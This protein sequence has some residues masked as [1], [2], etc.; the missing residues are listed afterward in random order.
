M[1]DGAGGAAV[2][3]APGT[4][5][6]LMDGDFDRQ[7]EVVGHQGGCFQPP[8]Q[9][10]LEVTNTFFHAAVVAGEVGRAVQGQDAEAAHG[11]IHGVM[12]D[13][14]TVVAFKE[15]R[16]AVLPEVAFEMGGDLLLGT[17]CVA[18]CVQ[19]N[20]ETEIFDNWLTPLVSGFDGPRSNSGS[21]A[22]LPP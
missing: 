19:L 21:G 6:E 15:Q 20:Y 7:G 11:F 12:I 14:R 2:E 3:A 1:E 8:I 22:R 9:R 5:I 10:L 17:Q 4:V 18:V 16:R 13:G